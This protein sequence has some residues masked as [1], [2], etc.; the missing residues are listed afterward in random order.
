MRP[1]Y[2]HPASRPFRPILAFAQ[3]AAVLFVLTL[4]AALSPA[5]AAAPA[6]GVLDRAMDA[7]L[8]VHSADSANRFLGSAFLWGDRAEVAVTNAHVVGEASEVRLI[9]RQ[10]RVV[11]VPVIARDSVRDIAVLGLD[12]A[13]RGRAG[14]EAG[15]AP[16]LGTPVWAMGAPLG[17]VFTLTEGM[18]SADPRQVEPAVPLRLLQHDAA[19]NPGSSGGPLVDAQGRLVGMNARIADGS[20]M[21]VGI[22]YAITATDLAR[23]VPRLIAEDLPPFPNLDLRARPVDLQLAA[24]LGVSASGLLI[25]Q[26]GQTGLAARAG[27]RAGD[28]LIA[29]GTQALANPG[30]LAFA[31]DTALETGQID[32]AIL[33]QGKAL[34]VT[35]DLAPPAAPASL[36]RTVPGD[37]AARIASYRLETLG[38]DL[39]ASG[40]IT[41]IRPNS[42]A[43]WSGLA[44]GDRI[45]AVNGAQRDGVTLRGLE[46]TAPAVLLVQAAGG[47]TRHV[48]LDPW[49]KAEGL[50]PIGGANVLDPAVVVF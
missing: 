27:L 44:E 28:I 36:T 13:L 39:D 49:S 46:L 47:Q 30:D 48:Y 24:A 12:G 9:D 3:V 10:G 20:R 34:I 16:D 50:R 29:A 25:D 45:L 19:V 40:R 4:A 32:L 7:V 41:A 37:S 23:L 26:V 5:R 11:L 38:F 15:P 35:L 43:L 17:T 31:I 2:R 6:P 42:P 1:V 18:I 8:V 22:A 33:R 14:L 21:F